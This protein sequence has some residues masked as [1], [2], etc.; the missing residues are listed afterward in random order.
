LLALEPSLYLRERREK[1]ETQELVR[2]LRFL[3]GRYQNLLQEKP[4]RMPFKL[5]FKK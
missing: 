5:S 2:K 1:V 3:R 4:L